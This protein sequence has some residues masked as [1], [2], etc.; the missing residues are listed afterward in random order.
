MRKAGR[1]R[2]ERDMISNLS[3]AIAD[4]ERDHPLPRCR[5]GS[6]LADHAELIERLKKATGPDGLLD[7]DIYKA[8]DLGK[9]AETTTMEY[10]LDYDSQGMWRCK[11]AGQAFGSWWH[12]PAYTAS[13]DA[14]AT[15]VPDGMHW[16]CGTWSGNFGNVEKAG[17]YKSDYTAEHVANPAIALTIAALRARATLASEN[18]HG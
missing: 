2:T 1:G 15:L 18:P 4:L 5:H 8:C 13:L 17:D 9:F 11:H 12:V 7:I 3:A 14:A 6:A 16:G 10:R